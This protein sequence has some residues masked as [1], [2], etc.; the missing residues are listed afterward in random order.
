[1][2]VGLSFDTTYALAKGLNGPSN[3]PVELFAKP[4]LLI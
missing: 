4:K 1:M 2:R 3:G